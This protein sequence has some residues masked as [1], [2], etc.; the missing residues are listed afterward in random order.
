M[1][2][3]S[4]Y[5]SINMII[6]LNESSEMPHI[7]GKTTEGYQLESDLTERLSRAPWMLVNSASN[8][9]WGLAGAAGCGRERPGLAIT[10]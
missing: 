5:R 2:E 8:W 3:F 9:Q 10:S 4:W 6:T 7:Q 1:L